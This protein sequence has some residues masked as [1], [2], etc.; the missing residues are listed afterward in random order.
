MIPTLHAFVLAVGSSLPASIVSKATVVA[1]LGL[2]G[3]RLAR[4]QRAAVRHVLLAAAFS[5][6][7]LLPVSSSVAPAVSIAVPVAGQN[8]TML[9]P[10]ARASD[11]ISPVTPP[12]I[13][14]AAAPVLSRSSYPSLYALLI[15]GWFVG[16]MLSLIPMIVS[17]WNTRVLRL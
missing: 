1:G 10:P 3:A 12:D 5:V 13:R 16:A 2:I 15:T 6:L 9:S 17:L 4:R 11:S 8:D 14:S 7:L